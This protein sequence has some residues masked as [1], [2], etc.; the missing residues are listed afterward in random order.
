MV[1]VPAGRPL[2]NADLD[3]NKQG[4]MLKHGGPIQHP[5]MPAA[6]LLDLYPNSMRICVIRT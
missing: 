4:A 1:A 2:I 6:T 3:L 5:I